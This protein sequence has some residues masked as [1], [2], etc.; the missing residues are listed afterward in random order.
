MVLLLIFWSTHQKDPVASHLPPPNSTS[1]SA[2]LAI[3]LLRIVKL[4]HPLDHLG[5]ALHLRP[6]DLLVSLATPRVEVVAVPGPGD[7]VNG[8][9]PPARLRASW[10]ELAGNRGRPPG[11]K[12]TAY[13]SIFLQQR[14]T[15]R[16]ERG[17]VAKLPVHPEKSGGVDEPPIREVVERLCCLAVRQSILYAVLVREH[18]LALSLKVLWRHESRHQRGFV[19]W[20]APFLVSVSLIS[21]PARKKQGGWGDLTFASK[22]RARCT[23]S[24]TTA[25]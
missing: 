22:R 11:I 3:F 16:R 10:A 2:R 14:G 20:R 6:L 23:A 25:G 7:Q 12:L 8:R 19:A 15:R 17:I 4:P 21:T 1:N 24:K 9:V 13:W 5:N 18:E